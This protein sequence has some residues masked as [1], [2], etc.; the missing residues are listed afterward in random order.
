[1]YHTN[2]NMIGRME[3]FLIKSSDNYIYRIRNVEVH[4][5]AKVKSTFDPFNQHLGGFESHEISYFVTKVMNIYC[6][7][8]QILAKTFGWQVTTLDN[9]E[10]TF[11]S[12]FKNSFN[13]V[14]EFKIILI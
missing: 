7:S 12:I 11:E 2:T 1:M 3:R 14:E 13:G 8:N 9:I 5:V 10:K 4:N 6:E